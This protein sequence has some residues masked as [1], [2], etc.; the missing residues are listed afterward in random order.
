MEGWHM[1]KLWECGCLEFRVDSLS[2][3]WDAFKILAV[4]I[5]HSPW[6]LVHHT[7]FITVKPGFERS[8]GHSSPARPST[9]PADSPRDVHLTR[10]SVPPAATPVRDRS[11][12]PARSHASPRTTWRVCLDT[13]SPTTAVRMRAWKPLLAHAT[14]IWPEGAFPPV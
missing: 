5:V 4:L 6:L 2:W 3:S 8:I 9:G 13:G 12:Q 11:W 7:A 1:H 10:G 14:C